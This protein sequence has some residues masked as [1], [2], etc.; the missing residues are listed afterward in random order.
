MTSGE[1]DNRYLFS[2]IVRANLRRF[3]Y[4]AR[5]YSDGADAQ[6]LLQ[7]ILLQVW[8]SLPTFRADAKVDT[9]VYRVA[10]NTAISHLRA[11]SRRPVMDAAQDLNQLMG[12][13]SVGT[14]IEGEILQRFMSSLNRIDRAI[15][16][17]YLDDKTYA[18]MAEIMGMNTNQLGVRISR[19]KAMFKRDYIEEECDG[20]R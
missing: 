17:L 19:I 12:S 14:G 5:T 16:L 20:A 10:L 1:E 3:E 4:L 18:E 6:D 8:R 13:G 11:T 15:L 9:W 2:D 7:E